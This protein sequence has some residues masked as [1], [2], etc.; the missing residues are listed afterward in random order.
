MVYK[1]THWESI[2]IG[3][4]ALLAAVVGRETHHST[5]VLDGYI[6]RAKTILPSWLQ[7]LPGAE[8]DSAGKHRST[9]QLLTGLV[10]RGTQHRTS[11][12]DRC[13]AANF[14]TGPTSW[15]GHQMETFSA[16]LAICAGNLPVP[17]EFPAQRPVTQSFNVFFDLCLNERLSKQSCGRWF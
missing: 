6:I 12:L 7:A 8:A 14:S 9:R 11:V 1:N 16:L 2:G 5:G 15:W 3:H 17:G 4:D 10:G 13:V